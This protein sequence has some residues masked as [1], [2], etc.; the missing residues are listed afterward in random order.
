M[1]PNNRC[2]LRDKGRSKPQIRSYTTITLGTAQNRPIVY[3][4]GLIH[5]PQPVETGNWSKGILL[6]LSTLLRSLTH[7]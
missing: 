4:G 5:T 1:L 7:F 2:R 6:F 3:D